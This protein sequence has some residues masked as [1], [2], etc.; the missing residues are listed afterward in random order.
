KTPG[1]IPNESAIDIRERSK[2]SYNYVGVVQRPCVRR[3][4]LRNLQLNQFAFPKVQKHS[5]LRFLQQNMPGI[6]DRSC[7]AKG[8]RLTQVTDTV[9]VI[10]KKA[11][12][13]ALFV[14]QV[15]HNLTAVV[16][17]SGRPSAATSEVDDS[18]ILPKYRTQRSLALC[19]GFANN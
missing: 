12:I 15:S 5:L 19:P 4:V 16:D 13:V 2:R 11:T 6:V 10:P 8:I 3:Q 7:G 1:L 18:A 17:G 9:G 14:I